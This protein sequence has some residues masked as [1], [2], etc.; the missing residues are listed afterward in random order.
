MISFSVI[1]LF[2]EFF[3][4][5][6]QHSVFGRAV[7]NGV[8]QFQTV[9]PRRW[10][11][12]AY[13]SVD[14]YSYGGEGGMT[15]R[16]EPLKAALDSLGSPRPFVIYPTP[17]GVPLTQD[18]VES[19]PRHRPMAIFC[20]H[21]EGLDQRFVDQYVDLEISVGDFVLTGGELP[22][23]VI[24]DAVS[25]LETGVVGKQLSVQQDSFYEGFLDTPSFSRPAIWEGAS[26]PQPLLEGNGAEIRKWRSQEALR[27]TLSRRPDLLS[28]GSLRPYLSDEVYVGLVSDSLSEDLQ[29]NLLLLAKP[30][31]IQRFLVAPNRADDQV[32]D[33][34][35][36]SLITVE[37]QKFKV[38]QRVDQMVN[39]VARKG[40]PQIIGLQ[41]PDGLPWL[42]VK[43]RLAVGHGPILLL[44]GEYAG[45]NLIP[46]RSQG[47]IDGA[48][49][50]VAL[51]STTLDRFFGSRN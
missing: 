29:T 28:R 47:V 48:L 35:R 17:Q 16:P 6:A 1:T 25:R 21:Y 44:L 39:W 49:P 23:M 43:R 3:E 50:D 18:L 5:F 31:Q 26:V 46:L 27:R 8:I 2:P 38:F 34:L 41:Q 33:R 11:L 42:E 20:G 24:M 15:L 32:R 4:A 22:A 13:Q 9:N 14:D 51:I 30:Y 40:E 45:D 10:G 7:K 12:G 37:G 19:L 36:E